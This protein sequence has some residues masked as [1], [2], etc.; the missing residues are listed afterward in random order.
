LFY[1]IESVVGSMASS[2]KHWTTNIGQAT[3]GSFTLA[4]R[5]V[6]F[7]PL[8]K[9]AADRKEAERLDLE[10]HARL[11]AGLIDSLPASDPP[12][13]DQPAPPVEHSSPKGPSF[14][15]AIKTMFQ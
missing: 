11:E 12:S 2:K 8:E 1:P 15:Q 4:E 14:W 6:N 10:M 3:G 5:R 7:A 13:P 9:D